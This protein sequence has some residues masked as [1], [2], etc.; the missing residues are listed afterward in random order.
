MQRQK[1]LRVSSENSRLLGELRVSDETIIALRA[2]LAALREDL[3][4]MRFER[5]RMRLAYEATYDL[6]VKIA[7]EC[8]DPERIGQDIEDRLAELRPDYSD[9]LAR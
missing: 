6:A 7:R 3:A 8:A 5:D 2:E 4:G 9:D 1:F